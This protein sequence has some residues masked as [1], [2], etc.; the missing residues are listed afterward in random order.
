MLYKN[1][2]KKRVI[3]KITDPIQPSNH[4]TIQSSNH[5]RT[6]PNHPTIPNQA[7][8]R[9]LSK[10]TNHHATSPKPCSGKWA[11]MPASG[12]SKHLNLPISTAS[13]IS[14]SIRKKWMPLCPAFSEISDPTQ[15]LFSCCSFST[16]LF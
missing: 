15:R 14:V 5:P 6:F 11:H 1:Y 3:N 16:S 12:I 13:A 9:N 8:F 4:P 2:Y 10:P 7:T